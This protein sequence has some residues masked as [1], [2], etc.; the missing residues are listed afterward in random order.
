M[1]VETSGQGSK[2][3]V[4]SGRQLL[5]KATSLFTLGIFA[6]HKPSIFVA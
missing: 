4:G 3:T 5:S 1:G 2:D 6:E